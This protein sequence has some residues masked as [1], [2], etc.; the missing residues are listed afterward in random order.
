MNAPEARERKTANDSR[1]DIVIHKQRKRTKSQPCD[2]PY[3]PALLSKMIFHFYDGRMADAYAEEN[4]R[5]Y[6]DSTYIHHSSFTTAKFGNDRLNH[7]TEME[8]N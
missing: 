2:K 1:G 3:P 7:L 8:Q 5:S 4:G 6:Y